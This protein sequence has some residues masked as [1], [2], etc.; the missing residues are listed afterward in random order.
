METAFFTL[1]GTII[2]SFTS[3]IITYYLQKQRFVQELKIKQE[4]FKTEFIAENTIKHYLSDNNYSSRT[5]SKIE[6]HLGGFKEDEL[7]K[8]L[9]RSGAIRI[10]NKN[11]DELWKLLIKDNK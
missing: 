1:L 9:V 3:G 10:Y 7:R 5:F 6:K 8:L 4:E 2:G 11:G